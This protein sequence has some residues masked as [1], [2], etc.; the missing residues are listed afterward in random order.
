M[1]KKVSNSDLHKHNFIISANKRHNNKFN[2]DNVVYITST[3][4]IE[5]I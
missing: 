5:L 4:V 1:R 3:L 2:Y